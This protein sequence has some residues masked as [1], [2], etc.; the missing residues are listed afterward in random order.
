MLSVFSVSEN[1]LLKYRENIAKG[2]LK[3]PANENY[4]I[5]VVLA[6]GSVYP[7]KG[8]LTFADT[9]YSQGTGTILLRAEVANPK[10]DLMPGQFVRARLLGA[11]YP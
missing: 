9:S 4:V 1:A 5:E 6:D 10:G 2:L 7:E 11:V 3:A 8:R